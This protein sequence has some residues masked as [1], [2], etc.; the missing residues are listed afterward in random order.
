MSRCSSSGS[1]G[2]TPTGEMNGRNPK[3]RRSPTM[4]PRPVSAI[5]RRRSSSG[6]VSI[7][8]KRKSIDFT[9]VLLPTRVSASWARAGPAI[10]ASTTRTNNERSV[11]VAA[12]QGEARRN[13]AAPDVGPEPSLGHPLQLER[14]SQSL[15]RG[16]L[17]LPA[18]LDRQMHAEE[19]A[20][21][22]IPSSGQRQ[23][24]QSLLA[25][26]KDIEAELG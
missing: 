21:S 11:R 15:A 23:A 16:L 8:S 20:G 1:K 4:P 24:V 12:P 19:H 25:D 13:V 2:C 7:P 18:Q 10:R 3:K 14:G 5:R 22:D 9:S 6:S 26:L 17:G